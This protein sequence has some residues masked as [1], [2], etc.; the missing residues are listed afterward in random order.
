M[1]VSKE[2][3]VFIDYVLK[4]DTGSIIDQSQ[5]GQPLGYLHGAGNLVVGLEDALAEKKVGD[6][7]SVSVSP[8]QGYGFI[9]HELIQKVPRDKFDRDADLHPGMQVQAHTPEGARVLQVIEV[10]DDT[11][12]LDAIT[13][14]PIKLC[15]SMSK[16]KR[17]ARPAAKKLSRAT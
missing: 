1:Q 15:I 9:D 2:K 13:P 4:D 6:K 14:S 12:T 8:E 16:S 10:N 5:N 3:V 11:V 17:Y 7:V